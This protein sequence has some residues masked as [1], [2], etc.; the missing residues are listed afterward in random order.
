MLCIWNIQNKGGGKIQNSTCLIRKSINVVWNCMVW[1]KLG[2]LV[3][4]KTVF[5]DFSY[6]FWQ[7]NELHYKEMKST[8]L[9]KNYFWTCV[10][11]LSPLFN[12]F[13]LNVNV[14]YTVKK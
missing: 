11:L 14:I 6:H 10:A 2:V 8:T 4:L 5:W 3:A 12:C 9:K 1:S 13:T 7:K